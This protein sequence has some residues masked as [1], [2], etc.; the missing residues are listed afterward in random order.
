MENY[1]TKKA[2]E[3]GVY[4][5]I[6]NLL[7]EFEMR[8]DEDETEGS[9]LDFRANLQGLIDGMIEAVDKI[10]LNK[11]LCSTLLNEQEIR[12]AKD[13]GLYDEIEKL[14]LY[15]IHIDTELE[16]FKPIDEIEQEIVSH[17]EDLFHTNGKDRE[18]ILNN[19]KDLEKERNDMSKLIN[20]SYWV[21]S[22][23]RGMCSVVQQLARQVVE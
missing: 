21:S 1:N 17:N 20:K 9:V 2:K 3:L 19:I 8:Y 23:A 14:L 6:E 15:S 11:P 12:K 13:L 5:E 18:D 10:E 7:S 16:S 4:E 22:K